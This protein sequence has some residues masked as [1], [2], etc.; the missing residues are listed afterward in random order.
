VSQG[1]D[2]F[3]SRVPLP[4]GSENLPSDLAICNGLSS[5]SVTAQMMVYFDNNKNYNPNYLRFHISQI[6]PDFENSKTQIV[7]RK[8]KAN[9]QGETFQ[10][11]TPLRFRV[12]RKS[13]RTALTG[14]RNT[15]QWDVLKSDLQGSFASTATMADI[16]KEITFLIELN[17]QEGSYDVLKT[18]IYQD[19]QW[20]EDYNSLIP[21]FYANPIKYAEDHPRVLEQLHL[22]HQE[23][24]LGFASDFF[25]AMCF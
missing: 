19:G 24:S 21:A 16:F 7:F 20:I 23:T 18:S 11:N 25:K 15:L 9:I 2:D 14:F 10:D 3:S 8:W 6:N 1:T 13:N 12:E 17:D 22:L 4:D 5:E